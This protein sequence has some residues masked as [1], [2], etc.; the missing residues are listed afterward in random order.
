MRVAQLVTLSWNPWWVGSSS[1]ML[2]NHEKTTTYQ[3]WYRSC[4]DE[5]WRAVRHLLNVLFRSKIKEGRSRVT[6]FLVIFGCGPILHHIFCFTPLYKSTG[7]AFLL[8]EGTA[9][10]SQSPKQHDNLAKNISLSASYFAT[11]NCVAMFCIVKW[12][13]PSLRLRTAR[14]IIDMFC[15]SVILGPKLPKLIQTWPP[16][17]TTKK[18]KNQF[19]PAHQP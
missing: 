4:E 6:A 10:Y 14:R 5:A 17:P 9:A 11:L 3:Q 12:W 8:S 7:M 18:S 2:K 1:G 16:F 13:A 15:A 19:S